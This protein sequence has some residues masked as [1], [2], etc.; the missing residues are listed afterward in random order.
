MSRLNGLHQHEEQ[1]RADS[2]AVVLASAALAAHYGALETAMDLAFLHSREGADDSDDGLHLRALGIRLF[3]S[4]A[5]ALKLALS[6]WYQGAFA[7]TRDAFETAA[8]LR[9]LAAN[10][11]RVADWRT[12]S[13]TERKSRYKPVKVRVGLERGGALPGFM[14]PARYDRLCDY[15]AHPSPDSHQLL[16]ASDLASGGPFI[17]RK[18]LQAWFE[19]TVPL[20]VVGALALANRVPVVDS[21]DRE[22]SDEHVLLLRSWLQRYMPESHV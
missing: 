9:Y 16:G 7:L 11:E 10:P 17:D 20:L 19:E 22:R 5:A 14:G 13:P 4:A 1:L 18:F 3:N 8:L 15:A 2:L 6:G 12:A 21:A